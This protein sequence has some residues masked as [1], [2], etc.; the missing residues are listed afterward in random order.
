MTNRVSNATRK[1]RSYLTVA[2]TTLNTCLS[3]TG[4]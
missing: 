4:Y 1:L 2:A 3:F